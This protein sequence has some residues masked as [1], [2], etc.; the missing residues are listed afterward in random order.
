MQPGVQ[1]SLHEAC[2]SVRASVRKRGFR[3]VRHRLGSARL[4]RGWGRAHQEVCVWR[5]VR[6]D[7]IEW[8][9][10]SCVIL[11]VCSWQTCVCVRFLVHRYSEMQRHVEANAIEGVDDVVTTE[12]DKTDY[13]DDSD[14]VSIPT[15]VLFGFTFDHLYSVNLFLCFCR[16]FWLKIKAG[17]S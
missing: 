11:L 3:G 2:L 5:K 14:E 6:S 4:C 9:E 13:N 15:P 16:T 17:N 8:V 1:V 12:A 10:F 7:W